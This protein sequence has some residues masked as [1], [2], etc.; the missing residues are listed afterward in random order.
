MKVKCIETADGS[1]SVYVESID[2]HYHSTK[3]ALQESRHVFIEA[4]LKEKE[5]KSIHILE[6][7]MGTGLNAL[8]TV[9]DR[10]PDQ[11][12]YYTAL[13]KYP[14]SNSI[15][16]KLNYATLLNVDQNILNRI[17]HSVW[18][19]FQEIAPGFHLEKIKVDL[20]DWKPQGAFD[21]V[22]FDAFGPDKQP[23]MWSM[24]I[25][26]TLYRVMNT[27]GIVVT[28]TAKGDVRRGLTTAG[29]HVERLQGPPG[30]KHMTR[31]R[32]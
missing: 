17:H 21:L 7:G 5:Q 25:Y 3:G 4:G 14:L 13:E 24:S 32:K 30:K 27:D 10:F 11:E 2:E 31:A 20:H 8:L 15:T 28:Y 18:G 12:V 19:A 22:Y 9:I 6:V 1:H 23:D 29:F 26:E 16:D